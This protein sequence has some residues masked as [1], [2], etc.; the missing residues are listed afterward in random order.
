V[1]D[2][3][4]GF[5]TGYRRAD[6]PTTM[7]LWQIAVNS[8]HRGGGIAAR[9]LDHLTRRAQADGVTHIETSVTPDN[10]PSQ[11]LFDAFAR[12]WE[13]PLE[14]SE[15]FGSDLFPDGHA[16]EQLLRIGPLHA[17]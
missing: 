17:H 4:A 8:D 5:L 3:P 13:A 14:R 9:M 15:L 12:R 7:M 16:A 10:K 11:R 1:D 6:E 2:H